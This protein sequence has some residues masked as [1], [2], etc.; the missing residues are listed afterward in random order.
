MPKIRPSF[1]Q[2]F[3]VT[4]IFLL[5][6]LCC[7]ELRAQTAPG[8]AMGKREILSVSSK[9]E[10]NKGEL[11]WVLP[12]HP[13][14]SDIVV[15]ESD[16][17][18]A[19]ALKEA[20]ML[21]DRRAR[22]LKRGNPADFGKELRLKMKS[23]GYSIT[24]QS[25]PAPAAVGQQQVHRLEADVIKDP[26]EE[27]DIEIHIL[28]RNSDR[29]RRE[30]AR[31]TAGALQQSGLLQDPD[32]SEREK[33]IPITVTATEDEIL[34]PA[35]TPKSQEHRHAYRAAGV[36]LKAARD[37]G[38]REQVPGGDGVPLEIIETA[39]TEHLRTDFELAP[40]WEIA[41]LSPLLRV[42]ITS[43]EGGV[44][45]WVI[46]FPMI[47]IKDAKF[48]LTQMRLRDATHSFS[49]LAESA[50]K[51]LESGKR[52]VEQR[53]LKDTP[54]LPQLKSSLLSKSEFEEKREKIEA[55]LEKTR[56]VT[57]PLT[58]ANRDG[59]L[60]FTGTWIPR[61]TELTAGIGFSTDKGLNGSFKFSSS[62]AFG[63]A[64]AF[65]LSVE[66]GAEKSTGTLSYELPYY[67]SKGDPWTADLRITSDYSRDIDQKLGVPNE[68]SLDEERW[69]F[70][71]R[72]ILRHRSERKLEDSDKSDSFQP[73]VREVS[74]LEAAVGL[75]SVSIDGSG[76]KDD[77]GDEDGRFAYVLVDLGQRWMWEFENPDK[78][79]LGSFELAWRS[80]TKFGFDAGEGD[81]DFLCTS[82]L[83]SGTVQFGPRQSRDY[84]V[85]LRLNGGSLTG[86]SPISEEFRFGGDSLV[87][88][89]EDGERMARGYVGG[90]LEAGISVGRLLSFLGDEPVAAPTGSTSEGTPTKPSRPVLPPQLQGA[91]LLAFV[92]YVKVTRGSSRSGD[93][94]LDD[95]LKSFGVALDINV[96]TQTMGNAVGIMIGYA[97]SPESE[98]EGGRFFTSVRVDF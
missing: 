28:V 9:A 84:L 49:A 66:A 7:P 23:K 53:A 88:G 96:P 50:K 76:T 6:A 74:F 10:L 38:L 41:G 2:L 80:Q 70:E 30:P 37:H 14:P 52:E 40:G 65:H 44:N 93:D 51:K 92:D 36:A 90:S 1:A 22:V 81:F 31:T 25:V 72:N 46:Q 24:V 39:I 73:S 11:V 3:A 94:F 20:V 45:P 54:A 82:A 47:G 71:V 57:E 86:T 43:R 67:R 42:D 32:L 18:L 4:G 12:D 60:A 77:L 69:N 87:R 91:F 89:L 56:N 64:D 79:G 29:V 5:C 17:S 61:E 75:S 62:N 26:V 63:D 95:Q 78:P 48:E 16:P 55:S 68:E 8:I 58:T 97:W 34:G 59:V 19:K 15:T 35:A 98:E 21:V 85:R 83:L 33:R 13:G 27:R